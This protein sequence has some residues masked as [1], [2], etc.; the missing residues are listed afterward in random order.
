MVVLVV[1]EPKTRYQTMAEHQQ[2]HLVVQEL[3]TE[4][5]VV[6]VALVEAR[7]QAVAVAVQA[8]QDQMQ[9][10]QLVETVEPVLICFPLG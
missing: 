2:K 1:V 8:V 5:V 4:T 9:E 3:V 10:L 7:N 6:E